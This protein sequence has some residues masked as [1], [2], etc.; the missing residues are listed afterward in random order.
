MVL[1]ARC[2]RLA[3][4]ETRPKDSTLKVNSVSPN[5]IAKSNAWVKL[6]VSLTTV[7]AKLKP[8]KSKVIMTLMHANATLLALRTSSISTKT[9]TAESSLTNMIT[10]KLLL[11]TPKSMLREESMIRFK[12][13]L[14]T[15]LVKSF[16]TF[17]TRASSTSLRSTEGLLFVN[18]FWSVQKSKVIQLIIDRSSSHRISISLIC[19]FPLLITKFN[20]KKKIRGAPYLLA[21]Y[22]ISPKHNFS[23]IFV[24][25]S[26]VQGG[27]LLVWMIE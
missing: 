14:P 6:H 20:R 25:K 13:L 4:V 15:F 9:V 1:S 22:N 19:C 26:A 12:R 18:E 24:H 17:S 10:D 3:D 7:P 11:M 21:R 16:K 8:W 2:P 5:S 27:G 23:L